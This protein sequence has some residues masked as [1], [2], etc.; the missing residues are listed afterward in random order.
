M[1]SSAPSPFSSFYNSSQPPSGATEPL[2]LYL[3]QGGDLSSRRKGKS[4]QE[5]AGGVFD[6]QLIRSSRLGEEVPPRAEMFSAT[7]DEI[8]GVPRSLAYTYGPLEDD[9]EMLGLSEFALYVSSRTSEAFDVVV[10]TFDLAPDGTETEVTVGIA[11]VERLAAGEVRRVTFRD[12]GD[13]WLFRAGHSIRLKVTNI[14]F[15]DFRPPGENDN[16]PSEVTI[17][18]GKATPSSIKLPL[19]RR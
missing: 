3:K 18:Y 12:F 1:V 7:V 14:D 8:A 11:R 17:H 15:P 19:R 10:R 5:R 6:P 9:A 2:T 13:H 4:R 16:Q